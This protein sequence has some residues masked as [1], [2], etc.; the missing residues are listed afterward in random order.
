MR[1]R[2]PPLLNS[3]RHLSESSTACARHDA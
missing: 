2:F 1:L 3:K